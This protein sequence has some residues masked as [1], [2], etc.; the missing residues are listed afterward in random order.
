ME[1]AFLGTGAAFYPQAGNNGAMFMRGGDL[2]LL[3]CGEQV[4]FRLM[5]AGILPALQG[6]VTVIVTH[7][8]ADHVGSL[9]TLCLYVTSVLGR[10]VTIVHPNEE[11]RAL[12]SLM[13]VRP[14]GYTLLASLD[15]DGLTAKPLP[16]T[17]ASTVTAFAY[18][19]TDA[20]GTVYYSGDSRALAPDILTG[21]RDGSI[22]H[23]YIDVNFFGNKV[24][25]AYVHLPY[26]ALVSAVEPALRSKVALMHVD[27]DFRRQAEA[28]GFTYATMDARFA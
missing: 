3:D 27:C 11:I 2:Y 17:H 4:F 16:V 6:D 25:E 24:P 21:L 23:A 8:H 15:Q 28:D 10:A 1:L 26:A 9:A 19:L 7:M 22:R 5:R 20:D 13:G 12:L 18:L 14:E